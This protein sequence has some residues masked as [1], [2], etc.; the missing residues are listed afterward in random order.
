MP[1]LRSFNNQAILRENAG[2]D[3]ANFIISPL[4][5]A[6]GILQLDV[7]AALLARVK[8]WKIEA[9]GIIYGSS[10]FFQTQSTISG[11][12]L[13][14]IDNAIPPFAGDETDFAY[15]QEAYAILDSRSGTSSLSGSSS[16]TMLGA[17]I[18]IEPNAPSVLGIDLLS[19]VGPQ[20]TA[21]RTQKSGVVVVANSVFSLSYDFEFSAFGNAPDND[22]IY[23]ARFKV[24]TLSSVL[25]VSVGTLTIR[26]PS[27]Q[28]GN[29]GY[30]EVDVELFLDPFDSEDLIWLTSSTTATHT[31]YDYA[32]TN[33]SGSLNLTMTP[34]VCWP[35]QN[36]TGVS[37]W[38]DDGNLLV[39][40]RDLVLGE[41]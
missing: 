31:G 12:H 30:N 17:G 11:D 18:V 10:S 35:Y 21:L 28:N 14:Q 13:V 5:S 8:E 23:R 6:A 29:L 27:W 25:S 3:G 32:V 4:N 41:P 7:Y 22:V 16:L 2:I 26:T 37:A 20:M 40:Y 19:R 15:G 36:S 1:R 39:S 9:S 33:Y 34:S 24:S 38:D